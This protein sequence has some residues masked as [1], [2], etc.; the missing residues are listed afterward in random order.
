MLR[1]IP[2]VFQLVKTLLDYVTLRVVFE[3]DV[4][5]KRLFRVD[6]AH[7]FVTQSNFAVNFAKIVKL[8]WIITSPNLCF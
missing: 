7:Y 3:G 1:E 6:T 5:K 2:Y 8:T 4:V